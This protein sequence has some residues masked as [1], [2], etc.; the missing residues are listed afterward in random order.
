MP[1]DL[2]AKKEVLKQNIEN[3]M[4]LIDK[5]FDSSQSVRIYDNLSKIIKEEFEKL[6]QPANNCKSCGEPLDTWEK[7]ICG[8]CKIADDRYSEEED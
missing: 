5:K 4:Q 7:E 2:N 3:L 6:N 8:P 1:G